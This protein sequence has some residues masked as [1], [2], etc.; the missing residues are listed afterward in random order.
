MQPGGTNAPQSS[1][2]RI[3]GGILSSGSALKG[4][5]MG[6]RMDRQGGL[7]PPH[8]RGREL[9]PVRLE[10]Q[11][12]LY[13]MEMSTAGLHASGG[14]MRADTLKIH[15]GCQSSMEYLGEGRVAY[16]RAESDGK[17]GPSGRDELL[18]RPWG[19]SPNPSWRV[20]PDSTDM[21]G[22]EASLDNAECHRAGMAP[23]PER[24]E[25]REKLREM[26][27]SMAALGT[28]RLFHE[29]DS[30]IAFTASNNSREPLAQRASLRS[31]AGSISGRSEDALSN[32]NEMQ[33]QRTSPRSLGAT[34]NSATA[35]LEATV[36][37]HTD[38][39][40]QLIGGHHSPQ[41][42]T[43][44]ASGTA[45]AEAAL[46]SPTGDLLRWGIKLLDK[47]NSPVSKV[48]EVS[49]QPAA[50]L[51]Q[52]EESHEQKDPLQC[53]GE[54]TISTCDK[55][56]RSNRASKTCLQ[57]YT[58]HL[59]KRF[60]P[61]GQMKRQDFK[62]LCEH[63]DGDISAAIVA[64]ILDNLGLKDID[65]CVSL[66]NLEAFTERYLD[67]DDVPLNWNSPAKNNIRLAVRLG[68]KSAI[69]SKSKVHVHKGK[70]SHN[71]W[72]R[73][74]RCART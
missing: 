41:A 52:A 33:S 19:S 40:Q 65:Q 4:D 35:H 14:T 48:K 34:T 57:A 42:E 9:S 38:E 1:N 31:A 49:I 67:E 26:E 11:E 43:R 27:L 16:N 61:S 23:S 39:S 59:H 50:E 20:S 10:M 60:A 70:L 63:L 22:V 64:Q 15:P 29:G 74:Q 18:S 44:A 28:G 72:I 30:S 25:M 56:G 8:G 62:A 45:T 5:A 13:E 53:F 54:S 51:S 66:V 32:Y 37:K 47:E 69:P 17:A 68:K 58:A 55:S 36:R 24:L 2:C 7:P 73:A 3:Q 12:K 71:E 46:A 6:R 21:L